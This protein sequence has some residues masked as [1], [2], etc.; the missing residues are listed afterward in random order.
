[1]LN[2]NSTNTAKTK[3]IQ[4]IILLDEAFHFVKSD[5]H[6]FS[7]AA[8]QSVPVE[9][10]FPFI[11]SIHETIKKIQLDEKD[12]QFL[13]IESPATFLPG[14][15]DFSFSKIKLDNQFYFLWSICDYTEVYT[16]LSKYQQLKNELDIDRQKVEYLNKQADNIDGL[17]S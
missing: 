2:P 17:F 11:E 1:M 7:T 9:K 14:S 13:R 10:W 3:L 5:D 15:Y 4:Q 12:V 16:Y 6:I 8:L